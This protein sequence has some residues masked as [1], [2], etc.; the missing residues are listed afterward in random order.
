ML[1]TPVRRFTVSNNRHAPSSPYARWREHRRGKRQQAVER[2][3]FDHERAESG[4]MSA[5][6]APSADLNAHSRANGYGSVWTMFW[7][8]FGGGAP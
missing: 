2:E 7:H 5:T 6:S 1:S 3:F 8:R 4:G